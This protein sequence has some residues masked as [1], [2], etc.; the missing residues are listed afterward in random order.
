MKSQGHPP[1]LPV[2]PPHEAPRRRSLIENLS[3]GATL[4][5][6]LVQLSS[7]LFFGD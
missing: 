7:T 6:R 1:A 5:W 4:V 2:Q 3:H